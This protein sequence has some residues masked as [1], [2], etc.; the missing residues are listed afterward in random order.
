M[1]W[2][3]RSK[4]E[5]TKGLKISSKCHKRMQKYVFVSCPALSC[6]ITHK[7]D[8]FHSN[9]TLINTEIFAASFFLRLL[10]FNCWT[11][12]FLLI[13]RQL[14]IKIIKF[15]G[16]R[17]RRIEIKAKVGNFS[18][19]VTNSLWIFALIFSCSNKFQINKQKVDFVARRELKR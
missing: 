10:N 3:H 5:I 1:V 11:F 9:F 15:D 8:Y 16:A 18:L 6:F 14:L 4:K 7:K 13:V 17:E 19:N 12:P 2:Y